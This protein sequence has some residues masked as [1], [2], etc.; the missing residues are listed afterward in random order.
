MKGLM[1]RVRGFLMKRG[2]VYN[3]GGAIW[4]KP[5][6]REE[7]LDILTRFP[8]FACIVVKD[9]ERIDNFSLGAVV[10]ETA[11]NYDLLIFENHLH[12]LSGNPDDPAG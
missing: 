4:Y 7:L 5:S 3:E 8:L 2:T 10:Q 1:E 11:S 12:L 6:N 9:G